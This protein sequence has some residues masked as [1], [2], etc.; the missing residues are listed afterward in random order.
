MSIKID[1]ILGTIKVRRRN[2]TTAP[3]KVIKTG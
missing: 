1:V 2:R 3:I